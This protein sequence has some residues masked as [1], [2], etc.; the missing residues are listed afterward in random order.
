MREQS[1]FSQ[2]WSPLAGVA[3]VLAVAGIA[4]ASGGGGETHGAGA[5]H[6]GSL[7]HEKLMDL[8]WRVL[9]FAG[10]A[11]ILFL[12]LKKPFSSGLTGRQ[13][14]IR[15]QFE[16]LDA[17]KAEAEQKYKEFEA[18]LSGIDQEAT[19]IL[20][21]ARA[22]GESEKLRIIE[23]AQRTAGDIKRQAEM[24]VQHELAEATKNLREEITDQ[25][26]GI[27]EELIKKSFTEQDQDRLV[28]DYLS[29]V[30]GL[31]Q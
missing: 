24:A 20:E 12:A 10:L 4:Y 6:G 22:Q 29:K 23:D 14:A 11:I 31:Q 26:M 17:Q 28:D 25:A 5:A 7:S 8:L 1:R 19:K 27:A 2:W 13:H 16:E 21:A 15:D 18:K 9:N 30:R 3:V